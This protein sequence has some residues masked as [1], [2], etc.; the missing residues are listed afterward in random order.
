MSSR[1]GFAYTPAQLHALRLLSDPLARH[2]MLFGGSRSGKTFVFCSAIVRRAMKARSRHAI[3]R[4]YYNGVKAAI[5]LDTLPRVLQLRYPKLC[6]HYNRSNNVFILPNGSEIWLVGLDDAKRAE[7]ILGRE[8]ATIY[9]NECSE[10]DYANVQTALTRLAQNVPGLVNRALYDCNPPPR[11]HWCYQLFVGGIDPVSRAVLRNPESYR[12]LRI[13]PEE[14]RANL[15]EGY[16]ENTLANLPERQRRRFLLGEWGDDTEGALWSQSTIDRARVVNAP[17]L[18]RIVVGV[19][20]AVTSGEDSDLT[21]IV[22]AGLGADGDYYVLADRSRKAS[23]SAWGGEVVNLYHELDADRVVGEVNNGGDLIENLLRQIDPDLS[24]RDV[25]ATRGKILRAEPVAA[26][27]EKGRVHHVGRFPD[28][29]DQMTGY[30]P[31]F[32][33]KSP[34]RMDALVWALTELMRG[35]SRVILA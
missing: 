1:T 3:I 24:Y 25:R 10:I 8:F 12:A 21:G 22:A 26:L 2:V 4:R 16:I 15:P 13:N 19:D 31:L 30:S 34:D 5:G 28:L 20:P 14:N 17:E 27:Y 29:E 35:G 32:A 7:K 6:V 11:S 18:E 33:T 9:F 23:P